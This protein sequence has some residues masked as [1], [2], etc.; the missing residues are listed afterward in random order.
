MTFEQWM[1]A[2]LDRVETA[3]EH[4]LPGV[5]VAPA[6]LHDAMRYAVLGGGKRV[7]PLLCHA[8]GELTGAEAAALEAASA[9]LEMIH[10]YSLVHDDMPAMDD[11]ALRRGKPTV[12]IQYDEA[13]AL[14]VG[15]ALQSQ[16]FITLTAAGN[17]LSD[18]QQAAL[19]RELAVA[20]G[21]IG[22]AGGQA[23]DLGSVGQKLSRPELET[24]HRKKTGALLRAS[25]RMG[26]LAGEAPTEA[27]LRALDDYSAAVGL[28]FQVVDD[29]LDVTAD[30]ATLGKTA[31]KDAKDD[32]P[33]YVS[34][35]G[36]DAS[37]EL[38]A[39]L[40]RDAHAALEPFGARAQ[41]LAE[42]ADLVV[43]R[44]H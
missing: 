21:S 19:V 2:S 18:R 29:I 31:G 37:R 25:V 41:R 8:A 33:T 40:R 23:I 5:D 13:T 28:A 14:L 30:S 42:L 27:S 26:A 10:V 3:L 11:D 20:S 44:V 1:R 17:A 38:A 24:M 36:L 39:Q 7:R 43:N 4:Y 6:R 12:H 35:I 32:K 9:A 34:I 16:A 15:D 22:M